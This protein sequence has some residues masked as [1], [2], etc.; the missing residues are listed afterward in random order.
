MDHYEI[1]KK[2]SIMTVILSDQI[3]NGPAIYQSLN[4]QY[5][6]TTQEVKHVEML[7]KYGAEELVIRQILH[8]SIENHKLKLGIGSPIFDTN[9]IVYINLTI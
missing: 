9:T 8:D 5:M 3:Y 1:V 2:S 7:Q 6:F 4:H